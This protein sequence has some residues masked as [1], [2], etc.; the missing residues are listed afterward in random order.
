M[1]A[2]EAFLSD[3]GGVG[4]VWGLLWFI[5]F[6]GIGGLAVDTTNGFRVQTMLQA[7]ADAA[8][9]AGV[10][11]LP[12]EAD[13]VVTA[14]A[15]AEKNMASAY[16]GEVL[17]QDEVDVGVWDP[18]ARTFTD[19]GAPA[20]AVR[21]TLHSTAAT[22]NPVPVNFLRIIGLMAW[23]INVQAIAAMGGDGDICL[24]NGFLSKGKVY[25]GSENDYIHDICIHGE[26][27][28]KVGST[29]TF[30]PGVSVSMPDL[31]L[32]EE[33]QDNV[34]LSEALQEQGM[35]LPL[36]NQVPTIVAG[37]IDGSYTPPGYITQP[38]EW[39]QYLPSNGNLVPGTMYVV[40]E[41][42][43]FGSGSSGAHLQISDIGVVSNKEIKT[44]SAVDLSNV[45][46]ATTDKVT[47]GSEN[48]IGSSDY[49]NSGLGE[50]SI[51]EFQREVQHL[52]S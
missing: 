38:I 44:G 34:G 17:A 10:Q 5:L 13:A 11:S 43:D 35:D 19:G 32:L 41:V 31:S 29:N 8:A 9:H 37:L 23:D 48:L 46:L 14:L 2:F 39:V 47:I 18:V 51:P 24:S 25:S 6:V 45:L 1:R 16:Y 15:Y 42:V 36:V 26:M 40:E 49:C 21:V 52:P 20:N 30:E 33:S 3:E 28:V 50:V 4:T 22:G 7:T 27:G 12:D